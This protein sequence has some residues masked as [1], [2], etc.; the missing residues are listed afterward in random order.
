MQEAQNQTHFDSFNH[1]TLPT[2]YPPRWKGQ[3]SQCHE[4]WKKAASKSVQAIGFYVL[5]WAVLRALG[6]CR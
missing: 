2:E 5:A 1:D 3:F 6:W 4:K